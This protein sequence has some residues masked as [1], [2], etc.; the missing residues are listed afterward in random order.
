MIFKKQI[1][2][3]VF[4]VLTMLYSCKEN[5]EKQETKEVNT[6]QENKTTTTSVSDFGKMPDGKLVKA[7]TLKNDSDVEVTV[8]NYGGIITSIKVPDRNGNIEEIA[9]GFDS[10]TPYLAGSP[11]FGALIGRYGN[12]IAKGRFEL[13]GKSYDLAVNNGENHLHGGEKGFDKVFW[14]IEE[15]ESDNGTALKLSYIS[16]DMEEGYPGKLQ[17]TVTYT[18]TN[19]DELQILYEATTDKKTVIN[20]TQHSYFNLSGVFNN[21][22]VDHQVMIDADRF[23]PV[24]EGLIP[25]GELKPVTG[26][27]FDFTEPKPI[28]Q[29]INAQNTQIERGGGYDHCWVLNN[30]DAGVRL[31]ATA[32]DEGSG[33]LMEVYTDE[34]GVQ[35]YTGN[36][37]DGTLSQRDGS[38]SYDK[39][40][41]FCLET[42]HFPD[43]PNQPSF[44]TTVL[45]AGDTYQ[46]HTTFKFSIKKD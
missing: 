13:D 46:S 17:V 32:Y 27:P 20:M 14:D 11:Y 16:A 21:S 41:G 4:I 2:I 42:Q 29:D 28:A 22:I 31:A 5:T 12:R 10:L 33:R 7:Y 8:I 18:L 44:P 3:Y 25:T 43:S 38:G 40:T 35:L 23:L 39:R 24:D 36:F 9:L 1:P 26:T 15:V 45:E 19:N 37:L 6:M 30:P 34:P